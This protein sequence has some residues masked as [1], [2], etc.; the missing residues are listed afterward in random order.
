MR[1]HPRRG[2]AHPCR[3]SPPGRGHGPMPTRSLWPSSPGRP[4]RAAPGRTIHPDRVGCF[5]SLVGT[6]GAPSSVSFSV[7]A[8]VFR[9]HFEEFGRHGRLRDLKSDIGSGQITSSIARHLDAHVRESKQ[10]RRVE[11]RRPLHR[12]GAPPPRPRRAE[13]PEPA[14][15][16][17]PQIQKEPLPKE[18]T[19]QRFQTLSVSVQSVESASCAALALDTRA[20]LLHAVEIP[21][22]DTAMDGG[23]ESTSCGSFSCRLCGA[24]EAAVSLTRTIVAAVLPNGVSFDVP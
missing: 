5:W 14:T 17:L 21:A 24:G 16:R 7:S 4:T 8:G 1:P 10:Y 13:R 12:G 15:T 18:A 2:T 3:G 20:S 23:P 22:M 6:C 9:V 19:P 11:T